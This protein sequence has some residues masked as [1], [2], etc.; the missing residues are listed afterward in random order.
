MSDS[1]PTPDGVFSG[2]FGRGPVA[3]AVTDAAV[4]QAM[5]DVELALV[6]ALVRA[7]LAPADAAEGLE[8]VTE[9]GALDVAALGRSAAAKG[10]PVPAL[11]SALRERLGDHPAGAV[12]HRGA[13]SQDVVDTALMLVAH[14]ALGPL[15][16]DLRAAADRCAEL[17]ERHRATLQVGRTLLQQAVPLTFGLV[18]AGWLTSLDAARTELAEVRSGAL[19]VQLGGAVGT[20]APLG[21]RG[22]DV[23]ADVAGELGLAVPELPW[24]TDRVRPARLACALGVAAGAMAKVARDVALLAQTEVGEVSEGGGEGRGGSST[25]PHKRNPVGAV[26]VLA[27][28]E[29]TPGLVSTMLSGMAQEHQR[30]AGGWQAEWETLLDLLRF[31]GSAADALREL[32]GGLHVDPERMRVNLEL[33]G[34]LVMSES[35][36]AALAGPLGR[37]RAQELVEEASRRAAAER[38]QLREVLLDMPEVTGAIRPA[39]F[40][41]AFDP[42]RYLGSTG[43]LIDRALARHREGS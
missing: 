7:G 29:R 25:M 20:L 27:C 4:V 6:E 21:D 17:A 30:A 10:T 13:T 16:D 19:A 28:A 40:E 33:T 34:G 43:A 39:E 35:V 24:H 32:L 22:L 3:V 37:P 12:L 5:V 8:T 9:A 14:R 15:L 2:L 1:R 23:V 41:R 11:V 31:T 42:H 38:G 36:A 26:A 18:A